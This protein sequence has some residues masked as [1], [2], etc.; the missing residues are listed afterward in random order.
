MYF[1]KD[2]AISPE[3]CDELIA[4][5]DSLGYVEGTIAGVKEEHIRSTLVHWVD[6]VDLINRALYGFI[7]EANT[8]FFGYDINTY[9]PVQFTKYEVGDMYI[10]HKDSYS[11]DQI[12]ENN[13]RKLSASLI[14]SDPKDYEGGVLEFFDGINDPI[15]PP[16]NKGT[17]VIFNSSDWHRITEITKG[18]RYSFV[19]WTT[20]AR[21]K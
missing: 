10:W 13:Q 7:L 1:S 9:E 20:G 3:Q 8:K 21:F 11:E 17:I 14:L 5:Y 6:S 18:V 4:R 16:Q 12:Q 2:F 15:R 19:I